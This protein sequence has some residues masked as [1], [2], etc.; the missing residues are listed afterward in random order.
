MHNSSGQPVQ[1]LTILI[2]KNLFLIPNLDLPS[3]SSKPFPLVIPLH[4]LVT[5]PSPA[6]AAPAISDPGSCLM[7]RAEQLRLAPPVCMGKT[8]QPCEHVRVLLWATLTLLGPLCAVRW[9]SRALPALPAPPGSLSA[10]GA[11]PGPPRPPFARPLRGRR[12]QP[13]GWRCSGRR[14]GSCWPWPCWPWS[15]TA[16]TCATSTPSTT[17]SPARRGRGK[18]GPGRAGSVS[19][20]SAPCQAGAVTAGNKPSRRCPWAGPGPVVRAGAVSGGQGRPGTVLV[21]APSP[22]ALAALRSARPAWPGRACPS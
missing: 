17:T 6:P 10:A 11:S 13:R 19:A 15:C 5:S 7:L 4:A 1:C 21:C 18:A 9:S 16:A 12:W 22:G 8:L 3:L 14:A 2:V 20:Q